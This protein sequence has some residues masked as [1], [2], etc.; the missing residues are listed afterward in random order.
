MISVPMISPI[1]SMASMASNVKICYLRI[2]DSHPGRS[3]LCVL[4]VVSL[5]L[6]VAFA[7]SMSGW[8]SN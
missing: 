7:I 8:S 4:G 2:K 3:A 6:A 1:S 5:G